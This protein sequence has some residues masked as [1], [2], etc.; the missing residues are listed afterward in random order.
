MNLSRIVPCTVAALL[1]GL[2]CARNVPANT[3]A[4]APQREPPVRPT[5]TGPACDSLAARVLA[6]PDSFTVYVAQP[7]YLL[8]PPQPAPEPVLGRTFRVSF[9]VQPN[10]K[11]A[12][13]SFTITPDIGPYGEK[14]EQSLLGG[15][16]WPAVFEGCAVPNRTYIDFTFHAR[17]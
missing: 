6:H 16:F 17:E 5:R 10:G 14:V 3:E 11:I 12:P 15:E 7:R 2:G 1:L 13:N 8:L 4:A 9:L